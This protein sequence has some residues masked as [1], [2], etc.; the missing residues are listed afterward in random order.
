L[1]IIGRD[2]FTSCVLLE[3]LTIPSSV[4]ILEMRCFSTCTKLVTVTF[5]SDSKLVR[6][7]NS[8]FENCHS[9]RSLCVPSSV[10]LIA[11]RFLI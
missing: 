11:E 6:I 9:L 2:A 3:S 4:E 8:V 10:K 5:L 1:T 7:E